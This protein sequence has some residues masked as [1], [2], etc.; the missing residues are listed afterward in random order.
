MV[1]TI[2][3]AST[4]GFK[5]LFLKRF[6]FFSLTLSIS[7]DIDKFVACK[8]INIIFAFSSWI[9]SNR[10]QTGDRLGTNWGQTGD[11]LGTNWGQTGDKLGT[12]S[13]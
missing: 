5:M 10:G 8:A 3:P 9:G 7:A 4:R 12:N 2:N 13:K 11:K 6:L 1:G